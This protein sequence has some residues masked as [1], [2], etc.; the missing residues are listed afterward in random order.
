MSKKFAIVINGVVDG[1]A[2]SDAP[3]ETDGKW[4]EVTDISPIPGP[5]W[6]Y[7]DG[8]FSQPSPPPPLPNII[9]KVAF[10]FRFTDAEYSSILAAA[11]TDTEVQAWYETFNMVA[12][13]DLDSQRTKDGVEN[14]VGKN[15]LTQQRATQILTD[16]VQ[17]GERG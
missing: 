9:T 4:I 17:P 14:L 7:Q 10:R 1:I 3:L 12:T 6:T 11:K 2:L 5:K 13:I 8:V 16:S 15:L